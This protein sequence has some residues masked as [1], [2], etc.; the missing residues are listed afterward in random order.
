MF[1]VRILIQA[2]AGLK[3]SLHSSSKLHS[4][5][6]RAPLVIFPVTFDFEVCW[7]TLDLSAASLSIR[8]PHV[9]TDLD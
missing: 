3:P 6:L 1:E 2:L 4:L 5:V 8:C 7:G 9:H